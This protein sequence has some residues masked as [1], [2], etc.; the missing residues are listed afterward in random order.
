MF[1]THSTWPC[2]DSIRLVYWA[3]G[4]EYSVSLA[5]FISTCTF[6]LRGGGAIVNEC[7]CV[8]KINACVLKYSSEYILC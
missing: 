7:A 6:H 3:G 2:C 4:T 5:P 1:T 8:S